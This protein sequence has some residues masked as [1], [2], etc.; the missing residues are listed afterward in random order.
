M[1]WRGFR[2]RHVLTEVANRTTKIKPSD[3]LLF[4][5]LRNEAIRLPYFMN[6]YRA[7]GV[8]HF[9]IVDNDSHDLTGESLAE[10]SDVSLW[11]TESSYK[12]SRFGMDWLTWLMRKYAHGHWALTVDADEL[13][14]YPH[15]DTHDLRALTNWMDQR[16]QQMLGAMMLDLYPKGPPDA[17]T[18]YAGQNPCEVLNWFDAY[19]YWVQRQPKMGNLWLQGGPRARRFFAGQQERAP[20]LNKIPLVNW[21]RGYVYVN[22]THNALPTWLNATFGKDCVNGVLLHTKFLPGTAERAQSERTRREHFHDAD[23]YYDYYQAL[24]QNPDLWC[25]ESVN[26]TGWQQLLDLGLIQSGDW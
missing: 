22:S 5:C 3:I 7:L 12:A 14:V 4:A 9:V 11:R 26:Y 1:L 10:Q 16:G 6:Y 2:S 19:G 20:T 18:Y 24:I 8:D 17:Q 23:L 25:A 21:Q 13:L 15:H